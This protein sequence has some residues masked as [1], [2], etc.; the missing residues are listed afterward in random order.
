MKALLAGRIIDYANYV[1]RMYFRVLVAS[2]DFPSLLFRHWTFD[3]LF[4]A[5]RVNN[6]VMCLCLVFVLLL[7]VY[8]FRAPQTLDLHCY[9]IL[10]GFS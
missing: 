3:L 9:K 8:P 7:P 10:S 5:S 4:L 1:R 6:L 2:L